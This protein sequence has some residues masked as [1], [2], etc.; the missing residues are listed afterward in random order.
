M[1]M[2]IPFNYNAYNNQPTYQNYNVGMNGPAMNMTPNNYMMINPNVMV[3]PNMTAPL[4]NQ[5][6]VANANSGNNFL[7]YSS[8]N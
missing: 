2:N 6:A 5:P 3:A 8:E 7:V 4:Q 1:Q